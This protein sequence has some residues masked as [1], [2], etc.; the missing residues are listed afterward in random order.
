MLPA[1]KVLRCDSEA[2]MS[3]FANGSV[4]GVGRENKV[5]DTLC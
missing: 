3:Q 2:R 4:V 1:L 5:A